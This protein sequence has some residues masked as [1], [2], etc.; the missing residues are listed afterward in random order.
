MKI[1]PKGIIEKCTR[2]VGDKNEIDG[3]MRFTLIFQ[4]IF[5]HHILDPHW[6][7]KISAPHQLAT[8]L[9]IVY[10]LAGTLEIVRNTNDVKI[11]AEGAYTANISLIL[12]T[13]Y[14]LFLS[15]RRDFQNLYV[16]LKS[17]LFK[18]IKDDSQ[19][20][21]K[22]V[23]KKTKM[24]VITLL[25]MCAFP[26]IIYML[27]A[28]WYYV[29]GEKVTVSKTTSIL[30]PMRTPYFEI[31]FI[32]HSI[33]MFEAAF[34]IVVIDIWFVV[35]MIFFCMSCDSTVKIL[36]VKRIRNES[37][38][39]YAARLNDS[40]R[41]FY[42]S[43]VKQIDFLNTLNA[44]FKWLAL[45]PLINVALCVCNILLL[46]SKGIDLTFISNIF[47]VVAELFVYNWFGEQIKSKTL[48]FSYQ[49]FTVLQTVDV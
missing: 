15:T 6:T 36:A 1:L 44:M 3:I 47:P 48:K 14:Y 41:K 21:V 4:R 18:S 28:A 16:Q 31:G 45:L 37:R 43:H 26:M 8:G 30:M 40:L 12:P 20:K 25:F 35:M 9:L 19:G 2:T 11:I 23:L 49:A 33:F 39:E 32:L 10:I 29:H 24:A 17:T 5:G 34:T 38:L 46:M 22:E 27:N 13:R 42:K 7:W